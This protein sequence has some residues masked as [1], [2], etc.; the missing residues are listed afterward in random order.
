MEHSSARSPLDCFANARNDDPPADSPALTQ[1]HCSS[2]IPHCSFVSRPARH[3]IASGGGFGFHV[4]G[5]LP[6]HLLR[7]RSG[8]SLA[9]TA[10]TDA[11]TA[12]LQSSLPSPPTGTL[13]GPLVKITPK[14]ARTG[15]SPAPSQ[16]SLPSP[17]A[18]DARTPP[19]KAHSHA[20][21]HG[22]LASH[23]AKL[24]PQPY[25]RD[26]SQPPLKT[27]AHCSFLITHS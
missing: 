13:A 17:P 12:P 23:L 16:S 2:L 26:D 8:L 22:T 24:T 21:S 6:C 1:N 11:S 20:R 19:R 25:H 14:P 4:I 9:M 3:W 7:R 5:L 27:I 18:R 15:R 10:S